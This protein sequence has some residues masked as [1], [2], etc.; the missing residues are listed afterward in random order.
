MLVTVCQLR[1]F[2]EHLAQDWEALC[3]HVS[4]R[5][6]D[7]VVLPEMPFWPWLC[8]D[9]EPDPRA[10]ARAGQAHLEWVEKLDQLS[11]PLV[12]A[13]RPLTSG[14][15]RINSGFVWSA[16]KGLVDGHQKHYLPDE[17]GYWEATWYGRGDGDFSVLDLGRTRAGF[18]ICSEL[19]FLEKARSY[20]RQG[21]H[22]LLAPR[23]ATRGNAEKWLNVGR[24]ASLVSGA[25]CLS[26]NRA[27]REGEADMGGQGWIIDPDGRFMGITSEDEPFLTLEIDPAWAEAAKKT[28]P[29][30]VAD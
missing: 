14:E 28:Y 1:C 17:P 29:R 19:W 30:N 20:G 23:A 6:S 2:G 9:P 11:A 12:A 25:F 3:G 27:G 8:T 24:T 18:L 21:A 10:W 5:S 26:S 7:L 16:P 22:L 13:T 4:A 15:Q